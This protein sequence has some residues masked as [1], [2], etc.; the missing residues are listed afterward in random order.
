MPE[1]FFYLVVVLIF[2]FYRDSSGQQMPVDKFL[3]NATTE[4][5]NPSIFKLEPELLKFSKNLSG[6]LL[7]SKNIGPVNL[8]SSQKILL[9]IS[10][11]QNKFDIQKLSFFCQKEWQFE[12]IT[13]IPLRFRL[14]SLEYTN[15]LEQ[16]PNASRLQ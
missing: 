15:Y 3:K 2:L 1:R 13:S 7:Y 16:K 8:S 4:R 10:F 12:K 9:R 14:G 11:S 5:F 6:T